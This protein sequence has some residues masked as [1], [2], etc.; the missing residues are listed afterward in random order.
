MASGLFS[1]SCP[2]LST[3][4]PDSGSHLSLP[5]W[6]IYG[7]QKVDYNPASFIKPFQSIYRS[8]RRGEKITMF[9]SDC[10]SPG[11]AKYFL[12]LPPCKWHLNIFFTANNKAA[13]TA[14]YI[15]VVVKSKDLARRHLV[16]VW[17]CPSLGYEGKPHFIWDT[18]IREGSSNST[19]AEPV[20]KT[21]ISLHVWCLAIQ[22]R[23]NDH[24]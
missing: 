9:T 18:K 24:G 16:F 15:R 1:G 7:T 21:V 10:A 22:K 2:P 5:N 19:W 17:H 23:S 3:V 6:H 11:K 12:L 13:S 4:F 20:H 8:W 14:G